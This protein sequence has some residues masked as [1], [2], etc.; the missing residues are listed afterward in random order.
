MWQLEP[1]DL[2][3]RCGHLAGVQQRWHLEASALQTVLAE[4]Q[5]E[6]EHWQREI[7]LWRLAGNPPGETVI[8]RCALLQLYCDELAQELTHVQLA[9]AGAEEERQRFGPD[10]L[11]QPA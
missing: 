7:C 10:P 3:D 9:L 2:P 11:A 5:A 4:T 1:C 6:L 8:Q